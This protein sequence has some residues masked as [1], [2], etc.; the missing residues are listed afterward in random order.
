MTKLKQS[1][2]DGRIVQVI[3]SGLSIGVVSPLKQWI[4]FSYVLCYP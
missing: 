4:Q 2:L 3:P 1:I